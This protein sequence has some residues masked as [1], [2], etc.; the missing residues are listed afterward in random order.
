MTVWAIGLNHNSA[1]LELRGRLSFGLDQ[2][3]S[4][5]RE[6]CASYQNT[7]EATILSTCNRTEIYCAS[8]DKNIDHTLTWLSDSRGIARDELREHTYLLEDD[9]VARHAFRVASGLD[10][11]VL[12]ESQI[13]GQLKTAVQAAEQA[14]TLGSSLNQLFQRSFSVAKQVRTSTDIGSQSISMAAACVRLASQLFESLHETHVLFIGA[15]EMIELCAAHFGAKLPKRI[16]IANRTP[17]RGDQLAHRYNAKTLPLSQVPSQLSQFDV[18][19][20]CTASTLPLIGLGAVETALKQRKNRPMLMIDLAVPRDIEAE[21]S[22]LES[23]YFYTVDDLAKVI[24]SAHEVR[25]S[26]VEEAELIID[27]GV[28]KFNHWLDQRSHVP[29][30]QSLT[31]QTEDWRMAE[32][33]KAKKMMDRGEPVDV[34]LASMSKALI[35]KLLHGPMAQLNSH[36]PQARSQ[37]K[38]ALERMFL[39]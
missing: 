6:F 21:V 27:A 36:D 32:L 7:L 22:K 19:I 17:A 10:S 3:G 39:R 37:A 33:V 15:G 11:M 30:I 23:V 12:G 9:R 34:V 31:A 4:A 29:L 2:L 5:L 25:Q 13:L 18:V 38:A 20:S 28:A 8:P 1:P 14:G 24:R 35:K 26:A 16:V